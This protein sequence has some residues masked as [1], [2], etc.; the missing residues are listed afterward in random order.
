MNRCSNKK[1]RVLDISSKQKKV[2][3]FDFQKFLGIILIVIL[4]SH[5]SNS[6]R[7]WRHRVAYMSKKAKIA[8]GLNPLP[9]Q[10]TIADIWHNLYQSDSL[11]NIFENRFLPHRGEKL[12]NFY[13]CKRM[14][15]IWYFTH[16]EG[17][18]E[19]LWLDFF[20]HYFLLRYNL[21]RCLQS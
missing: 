4:S 15:T 2:E 17:S 19:S 9:L 12:W 1:N 14:F 13:W 20:L 5:M 3:N 8:I 7:K 10:G 18:P 6:G 11:F 21:C 16:A